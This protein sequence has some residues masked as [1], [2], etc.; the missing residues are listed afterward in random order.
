MPDRT[1]VALI[2]DDAA[3]LDSVQL[4][5]HRKGF[6]VTC[7][8]SAKAFLDALEA[9]MEFQCVVTDVRMPGISGLELQRRL[10]QRAGAPPMI[11]ITGHG[12][13]DM[14]VSAMKAGAFDFLEKPMDERR[15]VG[16]ITE[17]VR[18][19]RDRLADEQEVAALAMRHEEL[20]ERQRQ[21]M[22]LVA[23]G[24]SNKEIALRLGI[25]PRTVEHYRE[26]V[27]ERMQA[28]TL[29]E[30]V[31]MAVRLGIFAGTEERN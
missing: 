1:S 19:S 28:A 24:F 15:L 2:D 11:L 8:P 29:A 23:Q 5:L 27:M 20:S 18:R 26:S 13:I 3:I 7:F 14:A 22:G 25:S 4:Y 30:L 12:D 31:R 10:S 16:S 21:V 17:A 9:R 6:A